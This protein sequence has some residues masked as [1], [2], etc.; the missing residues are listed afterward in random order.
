MLVVQ[1][2]ITEF[3]FEVSKIISSG[4]CLERD[5]CNSFST[6]SHLLTG[7]S[8]LFPSTRTCPKLLRF[9]KYSNILAKIL[10]Y[11]RLHPMQVACP[12]YFTFPDFISLIIFAVLYN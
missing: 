3:L 5:Q 2:V 4:D 9:I 8:I 7:F 1:S 12:S 6:Y 11:L 10:N